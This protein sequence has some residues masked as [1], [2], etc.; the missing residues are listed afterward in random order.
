MLLPSHERGHLAVLAAQDSEI[1]SASPA[2]LSLAVILP[3]IIKSILKVATIILMMRWV[4]DWPL[5]CIP[6]KPQAVTHVHFGLSWVDWIH[7]YKWL[8]LLHHVWLGN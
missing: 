2:R 5:I 3:Q 7:R 8:V 4:R 6:T 1:I